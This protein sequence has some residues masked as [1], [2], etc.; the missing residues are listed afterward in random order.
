[1]CSLNVFKSQTHQPYVTA[2]VLVEPQG[3]QGWGTKGPTPWHYPSAAVCEMIR[4]KAIVEPLLVVVLYSHPRWILAMLSQLPDWITATCRH[5]VPALIGLFQVG[6]NPGW[7]TFLRNMFFYIPY[8]VKVECQSEV[9][10]AG[11]FICLSNVFLL[12]N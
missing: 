1:M 8:W 11:P 4:C 6:L 3:S 5:S 12:D 9:I 10:L 7:T 2:F